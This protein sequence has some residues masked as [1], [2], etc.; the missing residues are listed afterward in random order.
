MKLEFGAGSDPYPVNT[1]PIR[2]YAAEVLPQAFSE[3]EC[4]VTV[5]EAE[6][7]FWEKATLVHAEYHR[8]AEKLSPSRISRH[9]Y[10]LYQMAESESGRRARADRLLLQRVVQHKQVYFHSGWAHYE[11]AATGGLHL[12]PSE[13]RRNELARDFEQMRDMI[14][15]PAPPFQE[16]LTKLEELENEINGK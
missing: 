9:Y 1:Y 15:G 12:C 8:P 4:L 6:R 10:D 5:L 11:T 13:T 3:P 14:F 2:P 16:I 7:T